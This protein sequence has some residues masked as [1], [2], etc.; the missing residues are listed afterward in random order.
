MTNHKQFI[1]FFLCASL[2]SLYLAI[3]IKDYFNGKMVLDP[4]RWT[5]SSWDKYN[6]CS[7]YSKL[8]EIPKPAH[9]PT[10]GKGLPKK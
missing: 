7:Q 9:E 3:S 2:T 6:Q 4:S 10:K 1:L 8:S 5:C